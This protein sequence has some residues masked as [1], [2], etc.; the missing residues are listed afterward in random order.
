MTRLCK[1]AILSK[2]RWRG[3]VQV[4]NEA[5]VNCRS[6]A[7]MSWDLLVECQLRTVS[8]FA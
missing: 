1:N 5:M 2:G 8:P 4:L 3:K 6:K 7:K